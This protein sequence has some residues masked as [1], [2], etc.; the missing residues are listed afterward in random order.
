[1]PRKNNMVSKQDVTNERI[2]N[3]LEDIRKDIQDIKSGLADHETRMRVQ[4]RDVSKLSERLALSNIGQTTLSA[5]I[6]V[7]ATVIS[8]TI[9]K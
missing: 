5:I 6:G 2:L 9:K 7:V 8:F 1:M 3:T 4:E